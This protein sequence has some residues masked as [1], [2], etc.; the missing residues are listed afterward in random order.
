MPHSDHGTIVTFYSYKGGTGRTTALAN[1]AWIMATAGKKVLAVDWDL[2]SPGLHKFFQP[3]L[4]QDVVAATPGVIELLTDYAWAA[5]NRHDAAQANWHL[6]YARILPHAVSLEWRFP[7]EGTLDFV[8]AGRQNRDYS[9]L[10]TSMDWDNFY[11]RLGGGQFFDAL[12]EDMKRN[13]DYVL[14]DSRTGLSDIADICTVTFPDVLVDCF[15]LSDQSIDGAAAVARHID[16]RYGDRGIRILPVPMR[17]EYGEN[18][19]VEAGR[20]LARSRF[21]RFPRELSHEDLNHYWLS[22][23]IPYRPFYAF[24]ETLATFGDS[25]GSPNSMLAA[26]ERLSSVI[27]QGRVN[28]YPPIDEN[29]RLATLDRFAR[30]GPA[31]TSEVLISYVSEDRP[32]LDWIGLI[33]GRA[34]FRV[35]TCA[36]DVAPKDELETRMQTAGHVIALLSPT[37]VASPRAQEAWSLI[38]AT[39]TT[40]SYRR[41]TIVRVQDAQLTSAFAGR[42]PIDL[43]G[44]GEYQGAEAL[45]RALGRPGHIVEHPAEHARVGPRFPGAVRSSPA[46]WNVDRRNAIF[47]GRG[48][49][50]ER[51][52]DHLLGTTER[53]VL[54]QAMHGLGGVG[55]TQVALEYAHRFR[56]DYDVV[57]WIPAQQPDS[58]R[59]SL[60]ALAERLDLRVG[61]NVAAAAN[62][63]LEALRRGAPYS[64]WLL[65]FDNADEPAMLEPYLPGGDGHVLITS[66]DPAWT[67]YAIPLP[68]DVFTE[69]EAA[70][71]LLR[72]VQG[73][74]EGSA[75]KIGK[76]LGYLPL[77]VEQAAAWLATTFMPAG[78]YLEALE[79]ETASTLALSNEHFPQPVA[80]T[81]NVSFRQLRDASPAAA[82]LLE[83]LAYFSSDPISLDLIYSDETADVLIPYDET[84]RDKLV[85]GRVVRE[86]NRFALA[87]VDLGNNSIQVHTLVQAVIREG[88][89]RE[90]Q[91][92]TCH[93]V[94]KILIGARPRHGDTDAPE[95]WPNLEKILPHVLPSHAAECDD[96]DTRQMLTDL[97][98]YQWKRGSFESALAA[99]AYLVELWTAKL[100]ENHW[101]FLFLKSQL[102]NV[103]RSQGDYEAALALDEE[104]WAQQKASSSIGPRHPH[105]LMTAGG[106]AADLRGLGRFQEALDLD[107]RTYEQFTDLYGEEHP[108]TLAMANNLG[109]SYRLVGDCFKA[110]I[111]DQETLER[112]RAV[113]GE[114]HPYTLYSAANLARDLREA[115]E[116]TASVT[117]L[118]ATY[119][120]YLDV[121][122]DE[123]MDT[124]RTGKSLAVSLRRAGQR[125][126]A[127][128][129][130][131]ETFE[132]Y[133]RF[134][135]GSPDAVAADLEVAT[136]LSAL[137]DKVTARDRALEILQRQRAQLGADHPYTLVIEN[138]LVIFLRGASDIE[139]A[140]ELGAATLPKLRQAYGDDTH[141]F[142]TSCAMNL[143]NC[144]AELGGNAEAEE[145]ERDALAK[146]KLRLG[147]RHPDTLACASNL[148]ITLRATGHL[149][150]ARRLRDETISAMTAVLGPLHPN[151]EDARRGQRLNRD[152]EPQ[153]T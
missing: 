5:T 70:T 146:L 71:H 117:L 37:Y 143:A 10:I 129:L 123:I 26:F 29:L 121:L 74:A 36:A 149:D 11:S 150:E 97:V 93:E 135:P 92:E 50:L 40:G 55:K 107:L 53:V 99:G 120:N 144:L 28:T 87:K 23:E 72:R 82:R 114:N 112:R 76:A 137:G 24:E 38:S 141:P 45:V 78:E 25:P 128:R 20:A 35:V 4:D 46:I 48:H 104:V 12:R 147:E 73:L 19:K 100:G 124:L 9:S 89:S 27:T 111:Y 22:V 31:E 77:A 62:S 47:T 108:R 116:F 148:S 119:Q 131:E 133:Q 64:R 59:T 84:L 17:I 109:V 140:A 126:E 127:T 43:T 151:I 2:E 42:A 96:E 113:L 30:R 32:W 105:T 41:L 130:A 85:L 58:I 3:F 94:H 145:L 142:A 13:Y 56:A 51:M 103:L 125:E 86:I 49:L 136:C 1:V 106:L 80:L 6:E 14:I 21:D 44:L 66:R 54:P 122:G 79:R 98:R 34:G 18:A 8:S 134:Y 153:P 65:I 81:W 52:R 57:W 16:E 7:G 138:N 67:Q 83:L 90:D 118:Q 60:A 61:E 132:R 68:V 91:E 102:A 152:L 15:T 69:Q 139:A 75:Q 39:Q 101:Q 88:M 63:A 33:L 110:R 95:N 115:G